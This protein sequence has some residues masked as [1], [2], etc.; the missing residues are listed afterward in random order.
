MSGGG[1]LIERLSEIQ[2]MSF[3]MSP[4]G[5]MTAY[6][7]GSCRSSYWTTHLVPADV[8]TAIRCHWPSGWTAEHQNINRFQTQPGPWDYLPS[9]QNRPSSIWK[10]WIHRHKGH[11]WKHDGKMLGSKRK[12]CQFELIQIEIGKPYTWGNYL[13]FGLLKGARW[14]HWSVVCAKQREE[15]Q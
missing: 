14:V 8:F 3:V 1:G 6:K 12:K 9:K 13:R 5:F 11:Q 7:A 10:T 4:Q 2:S 15:K